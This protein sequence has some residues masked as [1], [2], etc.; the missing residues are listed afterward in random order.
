M[1]PEIIRHEP[2]D[3]S[4]DA[5][6]FGILMWEVYTREIP[7]AN[8]TAIQAAYA[9]AKYHLRPFFSID[10]NPR[11]IALISRCWH[12]DPAARP[13]FEDIQALLPSLRIET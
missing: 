8:M 9:V 3:F 1:A 4:V 10:I 6:S 7:Y 2:Y 13:N 11:K 5:Y 12:Q